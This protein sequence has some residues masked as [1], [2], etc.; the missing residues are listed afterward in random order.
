M[1][2]YAPNTDVRVTMPDLT[3]PNGCTVRVARVQFLHNDVFEQ[4]YSW[5]CSPP[6]MRYC[7]VYDDG[8]RE[9]QQWVDARCLA[10]L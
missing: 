4:A 9:V 6:I 5:R 8:K 1:D 7:V 10:E 3:A 2:A